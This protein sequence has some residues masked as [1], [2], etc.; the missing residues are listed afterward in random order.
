MCLA[1]PA[2]ILSVD[3]THA[4]VE[5]L[6]VRQQVNIQF[7]PMPLPGELVLIHAGFAI[8]KIDAVYF[9]FLNKTL[10]DMLE[11]GDHGRA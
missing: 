7:I 1:V 5:T 8:E 11:A 10:F 6:G 3:K 4:W 9:E 2:R